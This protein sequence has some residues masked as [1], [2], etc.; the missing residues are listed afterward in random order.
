MPARGAAGR[1]ACAPSLVVVLVGS[2]RLAAPVALLD[3]LDLF[4]AEAEVVADL[5]NQRLADDGAH[6]VL[7]VAVLFDRLLE[8]GDAVRQ[9][10]AVGPLTLGQRRAFVQAVERIGRL[11]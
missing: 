11:D 10:V 7:V 4:L 8:N 3:L 6:L 2:Q 5:V 9:V 1:S